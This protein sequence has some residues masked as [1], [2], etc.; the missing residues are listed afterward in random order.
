MN[1]PGGQTISVADVQTQCSGVVADFL[2]A[3]QAAG[4]P[5]AVTLPGR[6]FLGR[7]TKRDLSWAGVH[8]VIFHP[9]NPG[10]RTM[11]S[12]LAVT[13]ALTVDTRGG[14]RLTANYTQP[15]STQVSSQLVIT[16]ELDDHSGELRGNAWDGRRD[17]CVTIV[18]E[19]LT[20]IAGRFGTTFP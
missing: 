14:W 19:I 4:N 15:P 2:Q 5:G 17:Q 9:P 7:L 16:D 8:P 13:Y 3:M 1:E 11:R 20:G 6:G 12:H 18:R 10:S